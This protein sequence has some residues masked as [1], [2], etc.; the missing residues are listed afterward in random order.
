[1]LSP[2]GVVEKAREPG[3]FWVIRDLSYQNPE[4]YSI[5]SFQDSDNF[6]T[7]W[8]TAAQVAEIVSALIYTELHASALLL[9]HAMVF[10]LC[11]L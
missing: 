6:P 4:R 1:M 8:G 9:L 11:T 10:V 5:N 3:K 2:L 7:E